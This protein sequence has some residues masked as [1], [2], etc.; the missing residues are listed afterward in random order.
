MGKQVWS[1][2]KMVRDARTSQSI[3][4]PGYAEQLRL[5]AED[6]EATTELFVPQDFNGIIGITMLL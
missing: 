1:V 4:F 3:D 2:G 5:R 6:V